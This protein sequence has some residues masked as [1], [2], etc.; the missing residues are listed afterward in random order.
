MGQSAE[1]LT[2]A[3]INSFNFPQKVV[4][5][6]NHLK[7]DAYDHY[8]LDMKKT[9]SGFSPLICLDRKAGKPLYSQIYDEFRSAIV[10]RNV[11]AGERV[12][13]SRFLAS[14]LGISRI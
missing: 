4:G 12:P 5:H 13:S 8:D 7:Q 9:A 11:R 14:E 1:G 3:T 10:S 6:N 2:D